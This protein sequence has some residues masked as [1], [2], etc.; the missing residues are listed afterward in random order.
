MERNTM[1]LT[2]AEVNDI[3]LVLKEAKEF[4]MVVKNNIDW[5]IKNI[6]HEYSEEARVKVTYHQR[7][8]DTYKA[9]EDFLAY[10]PVADQ[11]P[12]A[13]L[14]PNDPSKNEYLSLF[15]D[16][17]VLINTITESQFILRKQTSFIIDKLKGIEVVELVE[18]EL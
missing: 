8:A 10:C 3:V 5:C 14:L 16:L 17:G 9:I 11:F 15:G 6:N 4:G 2:I 12:S 13:E 18:K 1:S 7:L